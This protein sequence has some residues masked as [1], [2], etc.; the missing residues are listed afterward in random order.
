[1]IGARGLT[2]FFRGCFP[3]SNRDY[4]LSSQKS[5]VSQVPKTLRVCIRATGREPGGRLAVLQGLET[6]SRLRAEAAF[7]ALLSG[8]RAT[9]SGALQKGRDHTEEDAVSGHPFG[10]CLSCLQSSGPVSNEHYRI[11][12]RFSLTCQGW[13]RG[14]RHLTQDFKVSLAAYLAIESRV[15]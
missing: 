13:K 1:M 3:Q 4:A 15:T 12:I 14:L 10:V 6:E 9:R 5:Q 8:L 2:Y 7:Y 11:I